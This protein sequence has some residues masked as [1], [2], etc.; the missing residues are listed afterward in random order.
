M[1]THVEKLQAKLAFSINAVI[2]GIMKFI[3]HRSYCISCWGGV[4]PYR[5][6]KLFTLKKRCVCLLFGTK[7]TFDNTVFY[8]TCVRAKRISGH[9]AKKNYLL[10]KSFP[11]F[12][13]E[14][15]LSDT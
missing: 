8:E 3:S 15:I 10:E 14:K 12:N 7:P 5:L 9:M 4:T 13:K 1:G 2:K 6:S 11:I